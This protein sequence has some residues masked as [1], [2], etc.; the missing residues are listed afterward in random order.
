MSNITVK[1]S[2]N[3]NTVYE[4]QQTE[5]LSCAICGKAVDYLVGENTADGGRMGCEECWKPAPPRPL[6]AQSPAEMFGDVEPDQLADFDKS[7]K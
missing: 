2:E 7:I 5:S 3:G 6:T 1:I 4:K